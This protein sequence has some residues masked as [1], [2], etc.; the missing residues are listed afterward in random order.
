[1]SLLDR[2]VAAFN[3]GVRTGDWALL[4]ELFTDDAVLE[5][6]GIPVGP[7]RGRAAIGEAYRAQPPDDEI[8]VLE[9]RGDSAVYAW[10]RNPERRAGELHLE[11]RDGAI[12]RLRILYEQ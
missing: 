4:V 1:M 2:E 11:E 7:F 8:V 5:F 9:D 3:E 10:S 12:A 6:V